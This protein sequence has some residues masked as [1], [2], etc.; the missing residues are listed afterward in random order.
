MTFSGQKELTYHLLDTRYGTAIP[1]KVYTLVLEN[2]S[3]QITEGMFDKDALIFD[4]G[5][6]SKAGIALP[7]GTPYVE[8]SCEGFPNFGIWSAGDA[9]FVCLEPWMGRCD[10][11]GYN[12]ELSNKPGINILDPAKTFEKSYVISVK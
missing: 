12:G 1:D 6:I 3:C 2:G 11:I 8:I 10:N 7:D 5:Q 9:P 4:D